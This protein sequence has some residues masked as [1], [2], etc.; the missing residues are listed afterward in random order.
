MK[1]KNIVGYFHEREIEDLNLTNSLVAGV[2]TLEAQP[3]EVNVNP[4]T[5][6]EMNEGPDKE[7]IYVFHDLTPEQQN[8]LQELK[9]EFSD[10]I[11]P[12]GTLIQ[13]G[14]SEIE[15]FDL[16]F[17]NGRMRWLREH[18]Q[19]PF[20]CKGSNCVSE[21]DNVKLMNICEN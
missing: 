18:R 20:P 13:L 15:P 4:D 5:Q 6:V 14:K 21:K 11:L 17:V 12:A 10:V 1:K 19:Q 16:E 9:E 3:E 2:L 8:I 7:K